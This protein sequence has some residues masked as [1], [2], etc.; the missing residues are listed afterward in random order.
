MSVSSALS[1]L[2]FFV[3]L[4]PFDFSAFPSIRT[5]TSHHLSDSPVGRRVGVLSKLLVNRAARWAGR[6]E[7]S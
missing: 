1:S 2:E 5:D 4:F 7:E 3:N 6:S